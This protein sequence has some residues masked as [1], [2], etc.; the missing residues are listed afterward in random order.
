M[1]IQNMRFAN[2][3]VSFFVKVFIV[4]PIVDGVNQQN[5]VASRSKGYLENF[6]T[7]TKS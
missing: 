3:S 4:L 1:I 5:T 6:E 2:I 7:T